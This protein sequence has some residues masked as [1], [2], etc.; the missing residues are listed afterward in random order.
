MLKYELRKTEQENQKKKS[1]TRPI[2]N[3]K[4]QSYIQGERKE[5]GSILKAK[6]QW[7]LQSKMKPN[8]IQ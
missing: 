5:S 8:Q 3:M 1:K 6:T 4:K 2:E 7:K